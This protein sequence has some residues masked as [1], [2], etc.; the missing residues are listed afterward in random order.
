MQEANRE[1]EGSP[2]VV[3][4]DLLKEVLV[5]HSVEGSGKTSL[6]TLWW[7][8]SDLNGHLKKTERELIFW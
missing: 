5:D 1:D 4:F 3:W 7:L 2:F 6:E 8:S